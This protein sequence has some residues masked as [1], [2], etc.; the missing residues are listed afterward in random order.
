MNAK[1]WG[2]V[3]SVAGAFLGGAGG[4]AATQLDAAVPANGTQWK[5]LALGTLLGGVIAVGNLLMKSPIKFT[6]GEGE[7]P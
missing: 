1:T 7:K 4:Y 3:T 6:G 2:I 5:G